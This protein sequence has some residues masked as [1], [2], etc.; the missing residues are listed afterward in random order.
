MPV[1]RPGAQDQAGAGWAGDGTQTQEESDVSFHTHR[2]RY[3]GT[4]RATVAAIRDYKKRQGI[5]E[6]DNTVRTPEELR[7]EL[8]RGFDLWW[9]SWIEPQLEHLA[10]KDKKYIPKESR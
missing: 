8:E 9:D 1:V 3:E 4:I 6:Q 7:A 10:R 2:T 5:F